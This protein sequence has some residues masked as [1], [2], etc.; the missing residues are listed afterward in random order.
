MEKEK[1][2]NNI[3]DECVQDVLNE[4]IKSHSLTI[5]WEMYMKLHQLEK[6]DFNIKGYADFK[7]SLSMTTN[8]LDNI[9]HYLK[10]THTKI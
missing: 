1:D 3:V 7:Q 2:L 4:S 8:K 10:A 9:I 5:L 6:L